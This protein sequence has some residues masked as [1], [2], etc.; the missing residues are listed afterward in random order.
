MTKAS[1]APDINPWVASHL[2]LKMN[3]VRFNETEKTA[4]LLFQPRTQT[5]VNSFPYDLLLMSGQNIAPVVPADTRSNAV[6]CDTLW[7]HTV[8]VS[9]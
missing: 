1:Q 9:E 4:H 6:P 8:F 7:K 2:L 5:P 3:S